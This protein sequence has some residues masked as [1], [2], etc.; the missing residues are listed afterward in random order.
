MHRPGAGKGR[1]IGLQSGYFSAMAGM[2]G[3]AQKRLAPGAWRL[4]LGD[5]V[6]GVVAALDAGRIGQEF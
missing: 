5:V 6:R 4:P 3:A 2:P 1:K